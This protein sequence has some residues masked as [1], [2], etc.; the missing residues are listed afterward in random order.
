MFKHIL[1]IMHLKRLNLI[2]KQ[3]FFNLGEE[4]KY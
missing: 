4:K 3:S 2:E 1:V